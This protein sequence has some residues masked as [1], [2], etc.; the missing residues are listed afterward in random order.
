MNVINQLLLVLENRQRQNWK[1]WR[2]TGIQ[3]VSSAR[4]ACS[5]VRPLRFVIG[6]IYRI[7]DLCWAARKTRRNASQ[8]TGSL[9]AWIATITG[10][11]GIHRKSIIWS[12]SYFRFPSTS[13]KCTLN[14]SLIN[15][16]TTYVQE[17]KDL[18]KHNFN[19]TGNQNSA[20]F[21]IL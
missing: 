18:K 8:G 7:A 17:P 20:L 21:L 1:R 10:I 6:F 19:T 16:C 14:P 4:W 9:C 2:R 11:K 13:L 12:G 5:L 15:L 3:S